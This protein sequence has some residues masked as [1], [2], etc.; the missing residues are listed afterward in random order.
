[1]GRVYQS[2]Q[3]RTVL[4]WHATVNV[5]ICHAYGHLICYLIKRFTPWSY[6]NGVTLD[7]SDMFEKALIGVSA[8]EKVAGR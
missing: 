7:H 4:V 8:I 5:Q 2:S 6:T 1:M 3:L